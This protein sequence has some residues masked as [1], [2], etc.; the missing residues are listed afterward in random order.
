MKLYQTSAPD[1][2]KEVSNYNRNSIKVGTLLFAAL[3]TS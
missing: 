2:I 1:K 3:L